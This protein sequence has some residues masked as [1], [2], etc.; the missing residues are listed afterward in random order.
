M[1]KCPPASMSTEKL[2]RVS[3]LQPINCSAVARSVLPPSTCTGHLSNGRCTG[4]KRPHNRKSARSTGRVRLI[5]SSLAR[6]SSL[7]PL[8]V[9]SCSISS[10][11]VLGWAKPRS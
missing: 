1:K 7:V 10:A 9:R 6:I 8:R 3:W 11:S 4:S 2:P 5:N